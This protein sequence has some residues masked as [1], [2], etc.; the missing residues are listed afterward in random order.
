MPS[1]NKEG[2]DYL[3]LTVL[4]FVIFIFKNLIDYVNQ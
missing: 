2:R 3:Q 1:L 4:F